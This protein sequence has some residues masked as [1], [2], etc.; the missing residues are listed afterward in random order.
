MRACHQL[1][2]GFP[3]D[4]HGTT[5]KSARGAIAAP[6]RDQWH[7]EKSEERP[8]P[9]DRLRSRSV[10][11]STNGEYRCE[12]GGLLSDS[13]D[14]EHLLPPIESNPVLQLTIPARTINQNRRL[15]GEG[16]NLS[17]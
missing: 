13:E 14:E 12:P 11:Q 1:I 8:N 7:E 6:E 5:T 17:T 2:C 16:H 15:P 4:L 3:G 9:G 10:T